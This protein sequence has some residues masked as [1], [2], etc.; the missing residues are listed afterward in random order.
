MLDL[1]KIL[2]LVTAASGLGDK[3]LQVAH[4]VE[5]GL[6]LGRVVRANVEEAAAT[7][8]S[9]D[10]AR[11]RARADELAIQNRALSEQIDAALG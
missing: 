6:E 3:A 4:L 5:A 7:M 2:D 10:A 1:S 9:E 11:L 8:S